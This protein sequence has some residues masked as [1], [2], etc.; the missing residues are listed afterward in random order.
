V[1]STSIEPMKAKGQEQGKSGRRTSKQARID[2]RFAL[3][4]TAG[5]AGRSTS[6]EVFSVFPGATH[7]RRYGRVP[8]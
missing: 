7:A 2:K 8:G 5:V 1:I 6:L 3:I 4:D